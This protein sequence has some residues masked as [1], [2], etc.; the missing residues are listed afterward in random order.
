MCP[1]QW[2]EGSKFASPRWAACRLKCRGASGPQM[3]AWCECRPRLRTRNMHAV[4]K[5]IM[6]SDCLVK[7]PGFLSKTRLFLSKSW[8]GQ[9]AWSRS[10]AFSLGGGMQDLEGNRSSITSPLIV[11]KNCTKCT[12][13]SQVKHPDLIKFGPPQDSDA[14][15]TTNV[16]IKCY[17]GSL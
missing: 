13:L 6:R 12:S 17:P 5:M 2:F 9:T 14:S 4:F 1:S 10:L 3:G 7:V 11:K 8:C 15:C 16:G